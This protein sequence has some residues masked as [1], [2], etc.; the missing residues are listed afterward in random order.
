MRFLKQRVRAVAVTSA[1][2]LA[3]V[4]IAA[5]PADANDNGS[6]TAPLFYSGWYRTCT[7]G[8]VAANPTL[9]FL[10]VH[11]T[12]CSG[13]P[14]KVWD[15]ETGATVLSGSGS[16][17]IRTIWGLYGSAYKAKFTNACTGD[18]IEIESIV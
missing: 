5:S 9:H 6:C 10:D 17:A 12:S 7:T 16:T 2:A 18:W 3:V 15:T 14:W 8:P 1:I 4:L 11:V 13:S